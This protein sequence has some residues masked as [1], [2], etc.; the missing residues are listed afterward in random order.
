MIHHKVRL[1]LD[2]GK[3]EWRDRGKKIRRKKKNKK[4]KKRKD[5][6]KEKKNKFKYNSLFD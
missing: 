4:E 2:H 1:G 3:F 5:K 6:V